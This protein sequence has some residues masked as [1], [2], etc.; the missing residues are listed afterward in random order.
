MPIIE[1]RDLTYTY[2]YA[3]SPAFK[4]INLKVERG[5]FVLLTGLSHIFMAETLREKYLLQD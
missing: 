5:E 2:P 1:T 4:N 3:D